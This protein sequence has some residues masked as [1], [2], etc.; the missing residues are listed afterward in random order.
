MF[1][2]E[3]SDKHPGHYES[4]IDTDAKFRGNPDKIPNIDCHQP[5]QMKK[6]LETCKSGACRGYKFLSDGDQDR[7]I[8]LAHGG[9]RGLQSETNAPKSTKFKCYVC[10]LHYVT[11]YRLRDHIKTSGHK[12]PRGRRP[13]TGMNK[14]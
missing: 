2:P 12:Q 1:Q 10:K 11:D 3:L 14:K 5:S 6:E 4:Y 13:K 8:R 9:K 7:H